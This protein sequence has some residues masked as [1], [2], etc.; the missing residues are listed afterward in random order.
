MSERERW[1]V[2]PLLFLTLGIALRNQ[3][4]P[5]RRFGAMDLKAGELTAQKIVCNELA[6]MQKG[7]CNQF[8]CDQVQFNQA[9]G[10]HIAIAGMAE[11]LHLKTVETECQTM[12]V[13]DGEG[14][15]VILAAADKNSKAGVIQTMK[16]NGMPQVQI[17]S[18]DSGGVVTT[19]GQSGKVLIAMGHDGQNSGVFA[20]LPQVGLTYPLT[21]IYRPGT[22]PTIQKPSQSPSPVIPLQKEKPQEEEKKPA[23][24][25]SSGA[26]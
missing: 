14:K 3:F 6:V 15:P 16:A 25:Q 19:V 17:R 4:L 5:T 24:E 26:H 23:E 21:P 20:E 13:V 9:L 18:T 10:K 12:F 8:Q 2:Y 22:N 1:I 7:E 11:C